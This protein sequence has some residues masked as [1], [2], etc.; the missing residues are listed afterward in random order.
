MPP[1]DLSAGGIFNPK[2]GKFS[3]ASQ[4]RPPRIFLENLAIFF[5]ATSFLI[6]H[7]LSLEV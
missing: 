5:K 2:V 3:D 1:L 4:K 6:F 7:N